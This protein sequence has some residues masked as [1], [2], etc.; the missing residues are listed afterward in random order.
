MDSILRKILTDLTQIQIQ[1][2]TI[3]IKTKNTT[4]I[5]LT[6]IIKN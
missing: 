1:K 3:K 4:E 6:K 2:A 5:N